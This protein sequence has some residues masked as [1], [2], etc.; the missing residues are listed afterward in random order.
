MLNKKD[1]KKYR[2]FLLLFSSPSALPPCNEGVYLVDLCFPDPI[3]EQLL[4]KALCT[5]LLQSWLESSIG[6]LETVWHKL[7]GCPPLS[8]GLAS[9]L[10]FGCEWMVL[11]HSDWLSLS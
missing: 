5:D 8:K 2:V 6:R 9:C 3:L 11:P 4:H 7:G 10:S 1:E